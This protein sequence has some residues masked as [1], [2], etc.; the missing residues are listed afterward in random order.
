[1]VDTIIATVSGYFYYHHDMD[2][3]KPYREFFSFTIQDNCCETH[4]KNKARDIARKYANSIQKE[5]REYNPRF[6][7]EI[8]YDD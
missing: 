5:E 3:P 4:A 8:K 2:E 1:M 6:Y 7:V